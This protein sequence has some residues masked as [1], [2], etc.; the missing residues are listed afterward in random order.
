MVNSLLMLGRRTPFVHPKRADVSSRPRRI[1]DALR[2]RNPRAEY[3]FSHASEK[4]GMMKLA[5]WAMTLQGSIV[6][7]CRA[8]CPTG[9]KQKHV[10]CPLCPA[11]A[12][13]SHQTRLA[14]PAATI[15][16]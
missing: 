14:R 1:P 4:L 13:Q 12:Y 6:A 2:S 11:T 10:S 5:G 9:K 7:A 15:R 16:A 8:P 3:A